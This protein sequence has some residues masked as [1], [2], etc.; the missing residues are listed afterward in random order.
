[1]VQ[2]GADAGLSAAD[3]ERLRL[4]YPR[5]RLPRPLLVALVAVGVLAAG[6]WL[7]WVASVRSAP[8]VAARI[9]AYTVVSD[10]RITATL[11]VDRPDPSRPVACRVLSQAVDYQPVAEELVRIPASP[12]RVVDVQV[13]LTTLRRATTAV[14]KDCSLI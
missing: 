9:T 2:T 8:P 7:I 6:G 1:V 11:T 14:V 5:P 13:E 3:A 4:R 12:Y 10:T